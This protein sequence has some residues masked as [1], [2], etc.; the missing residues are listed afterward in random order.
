MVLRALQRETTV[1][2]ADLARMTGLARPTVSEVVKHL[3]LDGIVVETGQSQETRPGK[4]AVMLRLDHDATQV[5]AIDLSDPAG[6]RAALC[7]PDGRIIERAMRPA[8]VDAVAAAL[9][10]AIELAAVATRPLLGIGI[11]IP[12]ESGRG[13]DGAAGA[14]LTETLH[15]NL[16]VE[17]RTPARVSNVADL[18]ALAEHRNGRHGDFLMVRLGERGSTAL[19]LGPTEGAHSTARELA[20]LVVDDAPDAG[21]PTCV[22]GRSGCIHSWIGSAA[23]AARIDAAYDARETRRAAAHHLGRSLA[24]ITAA[25]DLKRVVISGADAIVDSTF[26]D[27]VAEVLRTSTALPSGAP[28]EVDPASIGQ[29][30]VLRGAAAHVAGSALGV[31]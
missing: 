19:H 24:G 5:I 11:G 18:V 8:G 22:C 31:R 27:D 29:D 6:F 23:L 28:I 20:H 14:E 16:Q 17:T 2:R 1:S 13:S 15:R 21:S 25:L 12:V 30:A 7:T 4:P 3:L 9:A 26:C 10:M